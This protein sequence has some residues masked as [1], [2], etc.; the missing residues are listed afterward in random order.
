MLITLDHEDI[1][2]AIVYALRDKLKDQ[3]FSAEDIA[4]QVIDTKGKSVEIESI[5]AIV[6]I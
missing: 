2:T 3:A 4:F 6:N 1:Q 5:T